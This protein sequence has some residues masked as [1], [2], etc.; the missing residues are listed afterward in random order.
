[1]VGRIFGFRNPLAA[2]GWICLPYPWAWFDDHVFAPDGVL[3]RDL[4]HHV[5]MRF[6][7]WHV[8]SVVQ[9]M[10]IVEDMVV[11]VANS[12]RFDH[13]TPAADFLVLPSRARQAHAP[14]PSATATLPTPTQGMARDEVFLFVFWR[15]LFVFLFL[16]GWFSFLLFLRW[17]AGRG[18]NGGGDNGGDNGGNDGSSGGPNRRQRRAADKS[19]RQEQR[20]RR[21]GRSGGR[22]NGTGNRDDN[23]IPIILERTNLPLFPWTPPSTRGIFPF[24]LGPSP[25][26][27][28]PGTTGRRSRSTSSDDE[29]PSQV[30][31]RGRS[32]SRGQGNNT[33]DD[34]SQSSPR[35]RALENTIQ[36][37]SRSPGEAE[38]LRQRLQETVRRWRSPEPPPSPPPSVTRDEVGQ[39]QQRMG[40]DSSAEIQE[41][42][43][44]LEPASPPPPR[45]PAFHAFN[46]GLFLVWFLLVWDVCRALHHGPE[47]LNST[48]TRPDGPLL[49]SYVLLILASWQSRRLPHCFSFLI[50]WLMQGPVA[51]WRT[52]FEYLGFWSALSGLLVLLGLIGLFVARRSP[53]RAKLGGAAID[54]LQV[55][56]QHLGQLFVFVLLIAINAFSIILQ[57][58]D[59]AAAAKAEQDK[60]AQVP[61]TPVKVSDTYKKNT[62]EKIEKLQVQTKEPGKSAT[63]P[64]KKRR[65]IEELAPVEPDVPNKRIRI[66]V[67][68]RVG[69]PEDQRQADVRRPHGRLTKSIAILN[70]TAETAPSN[71]TKA[72]NLQG[73]LNSTTVKISAP[74]KQVESSQP[75]VPSQQASSGSVDNAPLHSQV[76]DPKSDNNNKL[77]SESKG[78]GSD[79]KERKDSQVTSTAAMDPPASLKVDNDKAPKPKTESEKTGAGA[80]DEPE[81]VNAELE[82]LKTEAKKVESQQKPSGSNDAPEHRPNDAP[83][84]MPE[85]AP[86]DN[87]TIEWPRSDHVYFEGAFPNGW[88][89]LYASGAGFRCGIHAVIASMRSMG[90]ELIPTEAEL[91]HLYFNDALAQARLEYGLEASDRLRGTYLT[92]DQLSVLLD[93]WGEY[94]NQHFAL[95]YVMDNAAPWLYGPVEGPNTIIVWIHNNGVRGDAAHWS[96]VTHGTRVTP[97]DPPKTSRKDQ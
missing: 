86:Q 84:E 5:K 14:W 12:S 7:N 39:S 68:L 92:G 61:S 71:G 80:M 50:S 18:G 57:P 41:Q 60:A 47:F 78:L 21:G 87:A 51:P 27:L 1:M 58:Q 69:K 17:S 64:E 45:G 3:C 20:A 77:V 36:D 82:K 49:E 74:E 48:D 37:A 16:L 6:I 8:K 76:T 30:P 42:V 46:F 44:T 94:R 24:A 10:S 34:A 29:Q 73:P 62:G 59:D 55:V 72:T 4:P 28:W 40:P 23:S 32:R 97:T 11:P 2:D 9:S 90:L 91:M 88:T 25:R 54:F 79:N 83:Q 65:I 33:T 15:V 81:K 26:G 66:S 75:T 53:S 67:P 52:V 38:V 19:A 85:N 35:T 13:T 70:S 63:L 22:G 89:T 93:V 95:G 96:G 43:A 31:G 56:S